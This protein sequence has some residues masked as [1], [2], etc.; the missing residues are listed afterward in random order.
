MD[1]KDEC[2]YCYLI[3]KFEQVVQDD[4]SMKYVGPTC[5]MNAPIVSFK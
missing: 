2:T 1:V 3:N 4:K 5:K